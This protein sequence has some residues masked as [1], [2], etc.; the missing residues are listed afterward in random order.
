LEDEVLLSIATQV[1]FSSSYS[2]LEQL[3]LTLGMVIMSSV[4]EVNQ[5]S[6][7]ITHCSPTH[8]SFLILHED[9]QFKC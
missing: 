5:H 6:R 9:V 2:L 4:Y 3:L 8:D 1:F 7:S